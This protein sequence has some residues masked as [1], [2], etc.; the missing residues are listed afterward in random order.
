MGSEDFRDRIATVNQEGKRHWIYAKKP[1]GKYTN[2]RKLI[3]AALILFLV[4][5]PF[6][7][8]NGLPLFLFDILNRKFLVFGMAFWPQDFFLFALGLINIFLFIIAFTVIFGRLWCGWACPQTIFLEMVFRPIEHFIEG[9]PI[10]QKKLN[11]MPWIGEKLVKKGIKTIIYLALSFLVG[12]ILLAWI[13]GVDALIPIVTS[14]P[15][16]HLNG[17]LAMLGFTGIFYF[18][19]S[20]FREQACV[21]VCPYARLQG[22]LLDQNSLQVTYDFV[23]GEPRGKKGSGGDCV[24][25]FQC[26]AVCPTGIDIRN[27]SQLECVNCTACIDACDNIMDK[28]KQDRGLIRYATQAE[29]THKT[30]WHVSN[31]GKAYLLIQ[32]LALSLFFYKLIVRPPVELN[33]IRVRGMLE[34]HLQDGT[35]S[36]AYTLRLLNKT[37]KP[38]SMTLKIL[39]PENG[40]LRSGSE[41]LQ[42]NPFDMDS[43]TIFI[44]FPE[45]S[46]PKG[47]TKIELQWSLDSEPHTGKLESSFLISNQKKEP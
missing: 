1:A 14:S 4:G 42:V 46:L 40:I 12:N 45:G 43:R 25:C 23:R 47:T 7:K 3:A 30:P 29:L 9:D 17:F 5:M 6:I 11:A 21:I 15:A 22:V 41:K 39:S 2:R 34:Q 28:V 33:L 10:A 24:D 35:V 37:L 26:V 8:V 16:K 44:A 18:I 13:I 27:G 38:Q 36:N 19:F 31:R 32:I 20:W